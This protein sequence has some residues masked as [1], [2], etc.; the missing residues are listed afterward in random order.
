MYV[1]TPFVCVCVCVRPS[2]VL[3]LIPSEAVRSE[4]RLAF[5]SLPNSSKRWSELERI[6]ASAAG[7]AAAGGQGGGVKGRVSERTLSEIMLQ[8]AYPRL[9][10]NV[11]K[12]INHLLKS[13]FCV[14][15]KTGTCYKCVHSASW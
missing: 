10:I 3:A 14:H 5:E 15:P 1:C 11:S 8:Y 9:D 6:V 13:P 12:G 2:Q 7:R 4:S